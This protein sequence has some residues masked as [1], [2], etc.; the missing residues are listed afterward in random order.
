MGFVAPVLYQ[1]GNSADYQ[2]Y[3]RDIECGNTANPTSGPDGEPATKG[4]DDGDR[5]GR[6]R[7]VQLQH[8][9]RAASSARRT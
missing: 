6:A 4:W 2:S 1:M 3:F 9:L 5:L 8:R 7:L